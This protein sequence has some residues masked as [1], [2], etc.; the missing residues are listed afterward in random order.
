MG[1]QILKNIGIF[2]GG[3]N[4]SGDMNTVTIN[5]S[6]DLL[7]KTVFGADSRQRKAGLKN[8]E[9]SGGGFWNSSGGV[10]AST[11]GKPDPVLNQAIGGSSEVISI[12]PRGTGVGKEAYFTKSLAGEYSPGGTIGEMLGFTFASYGESE[13]L[14][15]GKV[16]EDGGTT[17][18]GSTVV[19]MGAA[20]TL[21]NLYL[22]VHV[23]SMSSGANLQIDAAR[24]T[25]TD[26]S[27]SSTQLTITLTTD[28]IGKARWASTKVGSSS[29][30][31]SYRIKI[32]QLASSSGPG[33]GG[34]L[35][36]VLGQQ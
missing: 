27:A 4:L 22:G 19:N 26:F 20:S 33:S 35:L 1:E 31:Y 14:I 30:N 16:L 8:V 12:L 36:T 21:K 15:R 2:Y 28:D 32:A 9:I 17:K 25:T 29:A 34:N 13:E 18:L 23:L 6:A 5:Y 7:D 24:S 3:H 11:M 10:D